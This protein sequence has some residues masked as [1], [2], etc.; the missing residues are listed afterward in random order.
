MSRSSDDLDNDMLG[1]F[2]IT[3]IKTVNDDDSV[4]ADPMT[5]SAQLLECL[6]RSS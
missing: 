1:I 4:I 3:L 6:T 5:L 2:T